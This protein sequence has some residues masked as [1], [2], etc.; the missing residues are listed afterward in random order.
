MPT[1]PEK[2]PQPIDEKTLAEYRAAFEQHDL[3][4]V[5]RARLDLKAR[6]MQYEQLGDVLDEILIIRVPAELGEL[7]HKIPGE[8]SGR[9][10]TKW[11]HTISKAKLIQR[12]VD[13]A[14]IA[15]CT[16]SKESAPFLVVEFPRAKG[17]KGNGDSDD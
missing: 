14:V 15:D 2:F 11:T 3:D 9:I 8:G 5:L 1:I 13:P 7:K 4:T 10:G 12:N 17:E 16:D 6:I